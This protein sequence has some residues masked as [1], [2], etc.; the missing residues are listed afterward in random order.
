MAVHESQEARP[1]LL[2]LRPDDPVFLGLRPGG[3]QVSLILRSGL[4]RARP[5]RRER[6]SRE[7][8]L[9]AENPPVQ[10]QGVG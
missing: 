2:G 4:L 9:A 1:I 7:F 3:V 6:L 8:S 5:L 10:L